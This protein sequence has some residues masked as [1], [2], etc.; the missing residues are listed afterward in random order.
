MRTIR[1]GS[2]PGDPLAS[3][4]V[5]IHNTTGACLDDE[6][7]DA[8]FQN[9]GGTGWTAANLA[10][11]SSALGSALCMFEG[12][13]EQDINSDPNWVTNLFNEQRVIFN[14]RPGSYPS[15]VKVLGPPL[16][17]GEASDAAMASGQ[18]TIANFM[19]MSTS[20]EYWAGRNP[21]TLGWGGAVSGCTAQPGGNCGTY[22][23]MTTQINQTL[24]GFPG[25]PIATSETGY[26]DNEETHITG[27]VD[28]GYVDAPTKAK[29]IPRLVLQSYLLGFPYTFIYEFADE[30]APPYSAMGLLD[31]SLYKKPAF[32]ALQSLLNIF[33]DPGAS[34]TPT[35]VNIGVSAPSDVQKLFFQKRD[36]TNYIVLWQT[37]QSWDPNQNTETPPAPVGASISL[38]SV[39]SAVSV[40]TL[41]PATGQVTAVSP[42]LSTTIPVTVTDGYVVVQIG[43][44]SVAYVLPTPNPSP[45][46]TPSPAPSPT[47]TVQPTTT[48]GPG[49]GA[50]SL[51]QL[52]LGV[53]NQYAGTYS[54]TWY[55]YPAL[56]AGVVP[57][58]GD[59]MLALGTT[60]TNQT[61]FAPAPGGWTTFDSP[62]SSIIN[63]SGGLNAYENPSYTQGWTFGAIASATTT[64]GA[65][66]LSWYESGG[67][68]FSVIGY[69]LHNV[70]PTTPIGASAALITQSGTTP[71][72][73]SLT[74]PRIG[75]QVFCRFGI[76][77]GSTLTNPPTSITTGWTYDGTHVFDSYGTGNVGIQAG[78]QITE[79][80]HLN[81]TTTTANQVVPGMSAVVAPGAQVYFAEA[82]AVQ[83]PPGSIATPT[84]APTPTP[85]PAPTP[86]PTLPPYEAAV[87]ADHP[88]AFWPLYDN[89]PS[90]GVM[91]DVSG[92]GLT[93]TYGSGPANN[94]ETRS[95]NIVA[96]DTGWSVNFPGG[97]WNAKNIATCCS[98]G[99]V[100]LLQPTASVSVEA[101]GFTTLPSVNWANG[102]L[103]SYGANS[104]FSQPYALALDAATNAF[105][106]AVTTS[107]GGG[108][109]YVAKS[110]TI[111]TPYGGPY[112]VTG[113]YDGA[114]LRIYVNGT[115]QA[116]TAA[117][118]AITG[119]QN[120]TGI[121]VGGRMQNVSG[122][123]TFAGSL[124]DVAVYSSVLAQSRI[125]AHY[126][127]G[128][129]APVPTPTPTPAPTP[130]PTATPFA[131]NGVAWPANFKP[132]VGSTVWS[133]PAPASPNP[134]TEYDP[135]SAAI[136]AAWFPGAGNG[137]YAIRNQEP[138]QYDYTHPVYFASSTDPLVT[139][140]PGAGAVTSGPNVPPTTLRIPA[141]ALGAQSNSNGAGDSHLSVVQPTGV[142]VDIY[143]FNTTTTTSCDL[144]P[145]GVT[146]SWT[147]GNTLG[148]ANA[149]DSCGNFYNGVG[150]LPVATVGNTTAGGACEAAGNITPQELLAGQ[151]NHA[152]FLIT[153]CAVGVVYPAE[154][155]AGTDACSGTGPALGARLWYDVPDAT[156]NANSGLTLGEKAILNALHDY[157]GY[158]M[159]DVGGG[160]I[161][162]GI[163]FLPES[164]EP[165]YRYGLGDQ[166]SGLAAQG[167]TSTT[168]TGAPSG[169]PRWSLSGG[170]WTP[171][172]VNFN[173]H[174]HVLNPCVTQQNCTTATSPPSPS[175]SPLVLRQT[176]PVVVPTGRVLSVT[177]V[178]AATP[179][180]T[181]LLTACVYAFDPLVVSAPTG[182]NL[183]QSVSAGS[184]QA[185][186][187]EFWKFAGVAEPVNPTFTET[188]TNYMSAA[189]REY[190]G[191]NQTTPFAGQAAAA[192]SATAINPATI[193]VTPSIGKTLPSGCFG[194]DTAAGVTSHTANA[195]EDFTTY[196]ST[197]SGNGNVPGYNGL[198]GQTGTQQGAA[199][200]AYTMTANWN[201]TS[202]NGPFGAEVLSMI[203]P[204]G[205]VV[206]TPTPSPAPTA[207]PT[208]G[209]SPTPT[210][211]PGTCSPSNYTGITNTAPIPAN[212][213]AY[214]TFP[215][216]NFVGPT[217]SSVDNTNTTIIR[218]YAA[219]T[220]SIYFTSYSGNTIGG[221]GI[222]GY[223]VYTATNSDPSITVDC[224][225][226]SIVQQGCTTGASA[227]GQS[228]VATT[229]FA[230]TFHIPAQA[231]PGST[232]ANADENLSVVQPDGSVLNLY[233]YSC[234]SWSNWT[235]GMVVGDNVC[236]GAF[237]GADWSN[238]VSNNGANNGDIDGGDDFMALIPHY[239]EVVPTGAVINHA[240]ELR[241][242][243][244][245][246]TVRFPGASPSLACTSV[247]GVP[248]GTHMHLRMTHAQIDAL[249]V[250]SYLKPFYY[251]LSDYG[252]FIVDTSGGT[253][254]LNFVGPF[255][256]EDASPWIRSG[257][258]NPWTA[259]FNAQGSPSFS[260]SGGNFFLMSV[261]FFTPI[262]NNLEVL[263]PCHDTGAC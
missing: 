245:S 175:P 213:C 82:I 114:N 153:P 154:T 231:R 184:G 10:S 37:D 160:A 92:N 138:G 76:V 46:P 263:L 211:Q 18:P 171:S 62:T 179:L 130:S 103:V 79:P 119:Y 8:N 126:N 185:E 53:Y 150:Q 25:K 96:N 66:P 39:P 212:F 257:A 5:T 12:A 205:V 191:V 121:A 129:G 113:T 209:P 1:D 163:Q 242:S 2:G 98:A 221:L 24:L 118:G 249:G 177:P 97:T 158:V 192:N 90:T 253:T 139:L 180:P 77:N 41:N 111:F 259:W 73:P 67:D 101:W 81:T 61:Y 123:N 117:T 30:G 134:A 33:K 95:A 220:G 228:G 255:S 4:F 31:Y 78:F 52:G 193:T 151:I 51:V 3:E 172:G 143:C 69:H 141:V 208:P 80:F 223:P 262:K 58:N 75:S 26:P 173:A 7:S 102:A 226:F 147:T 116:T 196:V 235:S 198:E 34:F 27:N 94:N 195:T 233:F 148:P 165:A 70:D 145:G 72:C 232:D 214:T 155:N 243:C 35:P 93:G 261:D 146:G 240:L 162:G 222:G 74:V 161:S 128:L 84:P 105:V 60:S 63:T 224:S 57:P 166:W 256:I 28:S 86:T 32:T 187:F 183:A 200:T 47:P 50:V 203:A 234:T 149:S 190:T 65:N 59:F 89:E 135:N 91:V 64:G 247:T 250:S 219:N 127:A 186:V 14:A 43:T 137:T 170:A 176:S 15:T 44:P 19:D 68:W 54:L 106:F 157:G 131:T 239:N 22:G 11:I 168:I 45:S 9:Q 107:T 182:W 124:Q 110:T 109:Q 169:Y 201:V 241:V 6:T 125:T 142:E 252:A 181:S 210:G 133:S 156:T 167:W 216:R 229:N 120:L 20:H 194:I 258:T 112:Y 85:T 217:P 237:V 23:A 246:G 251:A 189:V 40:M 225:S 254:S 36:G 144:P 197:Q 42:T 13:N 140:S 48:P 136:I 115:L 49:S 206:P 236:S 100:S 29:Y 230:H 17:N 218:Q 21:E 215:F 204:Q 244:L 174:M 104:G 248:S 122:Q 178:L 83:P 99:T 207:T 108:T 164:E 202:G 132:Y 238:L 260:N 152:L 88:V 71:A 87:M 38:S 188:S 199:A 55:G 16:A 56:G 159:D 227:A